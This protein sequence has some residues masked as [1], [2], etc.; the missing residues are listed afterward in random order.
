MDQLATLTSTSTAVV[1]TVVSLFLLRQG[2]TDR[3]KVHEE[4]ARAQARQITAWAEWHEG[5]FSTFARPRLPAVFVHNSSEAAV[6]DAFVDYRAPVD[7]RLSRVPIG[8]V[9]PGRTRVH[10]VDFEGPLLRGWEPAA[11]FAEVNF[12][13][14]AGCRWRRDALGRLRADVGT[15]SDD[16]YDRGGVLLEPGD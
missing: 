6:Y 2:Q 10:I 12:R 16:F 15:G 3:R 8:P 11:L 1:A 14:S 7:G 4:E 5:D 13:D 9:P